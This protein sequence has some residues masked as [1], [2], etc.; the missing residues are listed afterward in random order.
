MANCLVSGL[1]SVMEERNLAGKVTKYEEFL[2]E[3][4]QNDLKQVLKAR[5]SVY[6]E[7]SEY[8]QLRNSI[9]KLIQCQL[10]KHDLKTLVDLGANFYAHARVP[11]ASRIIVVIGLNL[12]LE[13]DHSEALN[14][15]DKRVKY[16]NTKIEQLSQE[17]A[18]IRARMKLVLQGLRELQFISDHDTTATQ[19]PHT[20][21]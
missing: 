2:N 1:L 20:V 5:D 18:D 11:D 8:L 3:K 15:I 10:P 12:C 16:L 17:A 21:W 14:F 4:L 9:D 19:R 7:V 6:E 13:M